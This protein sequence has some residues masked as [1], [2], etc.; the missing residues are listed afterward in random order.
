MTPQQTTVNDLVHVPKLSGVALAGL[1]DQLTKLSLSLIA[2]NDRLNSQSTSSEHHAHGKANLKD[3]NENNTRLVSSNGLISE[4]VREV[5]RSGDAD[6]SCNICKVKD[7]DY[8]KVILLTQKYMSSILK[9]AYR[10]W[11]KVAKIY[12]YLE[13]NLHWGIAITK[14][15]ALVY[16]LYLN[17]G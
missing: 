9:P 2:E 16:A 17:Q 5:L 7:H 10:V 13:V 12:I 3:D 11:V 15:P 4:Q 6:G 14:T 1:V 8:V